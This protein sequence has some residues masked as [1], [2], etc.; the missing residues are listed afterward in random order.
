MSGG[1]SAL[2]FPRTVLISAV[3]FSLAAGAHVIGG[4]VLPQWPILVALAALTVVPVAAVS[5]RPMSFRVLLGLLG[6]GQVFLHSAFAVLPGKGSC[7][8]A[9]TA[10]H[11][12]PVESFAMHCASVPAAEPAG[13]S[14]PL[15]QAGF[16]SP[17]MMAHVVA[18]IVTASVIA[19]GD[20]ALGH[21]KAW[22]RAQLPHPVPT[23]PSA[24][25]PLRAIPRA[26]LITHAWWNASPHSRRG[27]PTVDLQRTSGRIV[28]CPLGF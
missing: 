3:I 17:M 7:D 6:G 10:G 13:L 26:P 2:F 8:P 21:L 25:R 20:L 27:P 11:S 5:Y 18:V 19:R 28:P 22:T 9:I 24:V 15:V 16:F 14:L 12:H 23:M 4:G 1:R